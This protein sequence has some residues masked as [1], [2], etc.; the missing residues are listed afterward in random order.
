M[1]Q[2][3][4]TSYKIDPKIYFP[5]KKYPKKMAHSYIPIYGSPP[6]GILRSNNISRKDQWKKCSIGSLPEF[7]LKSDGV[8]IGQVELLLTVALNSYQN[9]KNRKLTFEVWPQHL[10]IMFKTSMDKWWECEFKILSYISHHSLRMG[11]DAKLLQVQKSFQVIMSQYW[12]NPRLC[13]SRVLHFLQRYVLN[14]KRSSKLTDCS[15]CQT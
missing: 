6:Q 3:F 14:I 10:M 11:D 5:A 1:T 9:L 8:I 13:S 2:K 7:W 15:V 4:I 12:A